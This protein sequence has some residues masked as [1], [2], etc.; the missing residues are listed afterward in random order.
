[1]SLPTG[2]V[3]NVRNKDGQCSP[4]D[5]VLLVQEPKGKADFSQEELCRG[6][7]KAAL[8]AVRSRKVAGGDKHEDS[9]RPKT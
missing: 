4:V 7:G 2:H 8:S 9:R 3:R 1:M 6:L 5:D